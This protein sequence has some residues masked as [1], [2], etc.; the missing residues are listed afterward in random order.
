VRAVAD[1]LH[2]LTNDPI[3]VG[4]DFNTDPADPRLDPLYSSCYGSGTG[5]F[6]EA[7]SPGCASRSGLNRRHGS[8]VI[9]EYTYS[10]HKFDYLFLSDGRWSA[11]EAHAAPTKNGRSDHGALWASAIPNDKPLLAD[12]HVSRETLR[13]VRETVRMSR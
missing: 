6:R 12:R 10:Q 5:T 11:P 4:G 9:N 2:G 7:D 13:V 1:I 3:V 8:D